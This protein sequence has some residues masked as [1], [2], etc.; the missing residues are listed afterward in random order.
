[1][2]TTY[3]GTRADL[4]RVIR[5]LAAATGGGSDSLGVM[6]PIMTRGAVVLLSKIQAAFLVKARGGVGEDGIQWK[7]LQRATI[8][9]RRTTAGERKSLGIGGTRTRGLL[10]PAQDKRWRAIYRSTLA[11]LAARGVS[12]AASLAAQ[13]AWA[14]LKSE[15]AKTKLQVLGGRTVEIG[16]DTGALLRSLT[17]GAEE[18]PAKPPGQIFDVQPGRITVGSNLP[19]AGPFHASRPLWPDVLPAVWLDAVTE[20][21]ARGLLKEIARAVSSGRRA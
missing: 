2:S 12:G 3:R 8:A 7:P 15:G 16:R 20:A 17:P 4:V 1:M 19:Y 18:S 5:E 9:A 10:T 21:V 14:I 13:R 6:R 11:N